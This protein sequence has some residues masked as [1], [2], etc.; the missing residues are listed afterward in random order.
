MH[1]PTGV[2]TKQLLKGAFDRPKAGLIKIG[3]GGHEHDGILEIV[4]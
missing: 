4:V 2:E 1:L 3:G